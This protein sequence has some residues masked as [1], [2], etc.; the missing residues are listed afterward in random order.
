MISEF[1]KIEKLPCEKKR[2]KH[3]PTESYFHLTREIAKCM[4]RSEKLNWYM[5]GGYKEMTAPYSNVN[6]TN[7]DE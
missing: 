2:L 4:T 3:E 1:D 7:E 5:H 6:V